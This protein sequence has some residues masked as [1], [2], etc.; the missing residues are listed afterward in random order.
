MILGHLRSL[1]KDSLIYG[2]GNASASVVSFLLLPLYTRFLNPEDYGILAVF[3]MYQS[4]IELSVSFGLSSGL[5][6]YYLMAKTEEEKREVLGT[7]FIIQVGLVVLLGAVLMG[8]SGLISSALFKTVD[9]SHKF[10]IVTATS[11]LGAV[12]TLFYALMRAERKT[13]LFSGI[14]IGRTMVMAVSNILLVAVLK[15]NYTGVILSNFIVAGLLMVSMSPFLLRKFLAPLSTRL[16]WRIL[17]FVAPVFVINA[18]SFLLGMSDRFFLN[19]YLTPDQVGLYSFG[20]KIGSIISVGLITPFSTAVVPYALSIATR[21]DFKEIFSRIIKYF[22]MTAFFCSLPIFFFSKEI[23][24]LVGRDAYVG[25][26]SVVGPTL[27]AGILFG[28]YYAVSIQLD[29]VE[30]TYLS[31]FAVAL[32]G[33]SSVA[34][35]LIL[36]PKLGMF[37]SALSACGANAILLVAMFIF[38]QRMLPIPHEVGAYLKL[39]GLACLAV[40]FSW[41]IESHVPGVAL[42]IV[43]KSVFLLL[44]PGALVALGIL[45]ASERKSLRRG[46]HKFTAAPAR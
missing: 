18:F 43:W 15:M 5:F 46:L 39:L 17:A 12:P 16:I 8:S 27:L 38:C 25:A 32:G 28:L 35:N 41:W 14:Q 34:L 37:G 29:I 26:S 22:A 44:S 31:S 36:I 1:S 10:R 45:N 40:C 9:L 11:L 7:C 19:K 4:I 21:D 30:K 6:R 2:L 20:N 33:V 23:I 13:K 42:R 3:T 24:L